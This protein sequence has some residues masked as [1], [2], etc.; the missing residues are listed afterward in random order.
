MDPSHSDYLYT[1][2]LLA[3]SFVGFTAIVMILRQ[4]LGGQLSRYDALVTR[5]FMVWGFLIAYG[6]MAPPLLL[7]FGL[8]PALAF[9]F[10][11]LAAGLMLLALSFGYPLLRAR[12]V[13]ERPPAFVYGQSAAGAVIGV[14][15]L[16]D[17]IAPFGA[18]LVSAIYLAV[19]TF[20]LAQASVGFI[21]TIN[22]MLT[23]TEPK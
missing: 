19:L 10:C 9:A 17:A 22:V 4:S 21:V 18:G 6:A 11:S 5:F 2:A 20:T 16:V 23:Q 8:S 15:L 12:A 3:M 13:A 1:L 7:A 14:I